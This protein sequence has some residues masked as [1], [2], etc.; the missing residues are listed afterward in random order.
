MLAQL[1]RD[2]RKIV[3]KIKKSQI[4]SFIQLLKENEVS[5]IRNFQ[6]ASFFDPH[7]SRNYHVKR[8]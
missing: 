8:D 2:N 7:P 4:D 5:S 1:I 6:A 3:D